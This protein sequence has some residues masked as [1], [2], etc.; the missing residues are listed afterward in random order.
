MVPFP[1]VEALPPLPPAPG[2]QPVSRRRRRAAVIGQAISAVGAIILLASLFVGGWYHVRHIDV[3]LGG[4]QVNDSY[5][6]TALEAYTNHYSLAIWAFLK[7]GYAI[8]AV[9]A[10]LLAAAATLLI[11]GGRRRSLVALG[12]PFAA[13]TVAF[14]IVDLRRFPATMAAMASD[15]PGFPSDIRLHG[16]RPG[17]MM[18]LAFGGLSLQIGGALLALFC[19]PRVRRA[20]RVSR[21]QRKPEREEQPVHELQPRGAGE[22]AVQGAALPSAQAA[23]QWWHEGQGEQREQ[24]PG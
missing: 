20:R 13:A 7:R 5:V 12:L 4:R 9:I 19:L 2:A 23:E 10:A 11:V 22:Y 14:I 1:Q 17:I 6:G 16:L 21:A 18:L 8:P 3:T 24:H 15:S